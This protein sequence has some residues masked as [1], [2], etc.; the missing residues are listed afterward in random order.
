MHG[1]L[2]VEGLGGGVGG[3]SGADRRLGWPVLTCR[4]WLV[5]SKEYV[6]IPEGSRLS[7]VAF[8]TEAKV[9]G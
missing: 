7:F 8:A 5:G 2:V 1:C 3:C 9:E 6:L 4:S